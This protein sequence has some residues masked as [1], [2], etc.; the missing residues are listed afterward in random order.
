MQTDDIKQL[1]IKLAAVADSFEARG[2][3]SVH[4][5]GQSA[6]SIA[7]AAQQ[8]ASSSEQLTRQAVLAFKEEASV[9]LAQ[10]LDTPLAECKHKLQASA[11]ALE[12]ATSDLQRQMEVARKAHVATAWK[13]FIVSAVA[14]VLVLAVAGYVLFTT[15]REV[16]RSEWVGAINA[17]VAN[18]KLVACPDGGICAN[19]DRKLIRLDK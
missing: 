10:G 5:I 2:D 12:Q 7:Y 18:G 16:K 6:K 8:A 4:A 1:A 9:A 19:V 13:A 17:A 14:C 15:V 3:K 11:H